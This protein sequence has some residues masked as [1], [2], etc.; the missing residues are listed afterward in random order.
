[1]MPAYYLILTIFYGNV[2][3]IEKIPMQTEIACQQAG[4]V[5]TA[6][7]KEISGWSRSVSFVCVKTN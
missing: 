1:M 4:S 3:T 6:K 5:Y 7:M 2:A